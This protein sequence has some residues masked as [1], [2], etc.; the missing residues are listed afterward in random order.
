MIKN[1]IQIFKNFIS[2]KDMQQYYL[3][4][5]IIL[6]DEQLLWL[7]QHSFAGIY[8]KKWGL[9]KII[10]ETENDN[11]RNQAISILKNSNIDEKYIYNNPDKYNVLLL[12][13][14]EN[15]TMN[16][17]SKFECTK[18]AIIY[19][20]HLNRKLGKY[21]MIALDDR[22]LDDKK[23]SFRS[24]I[25]LDNNGSEYDISTDCDH[26][27]IKNSICDMYF[28]FPSPFKNGNIVSIIMYPVWNS[29]ILNCTVKSKTEYFLG[30]DDSDVGLLMNELDFPVSPF[31]I[32]YYKGK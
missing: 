8:L 2:S 6:S 9:E 28:D 1:Q 11:V 27:K 19:L 32:E 30:A 26:I 18:K 4:N 10:F 13:I 23:L 16:I 22:D 15:G 17:I 3:N 31:N 21:Y 5:N 7:I 29:N 20:R 25:I 24:Y 14:L 12:E